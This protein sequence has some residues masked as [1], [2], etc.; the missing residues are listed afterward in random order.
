VTVTSREISLLLFLISFMKT[1][2]AMILLAV[3]GCASDCGL[4]PWNNP[5]TADIFPHKMRY[6]GQQDSSPG[7]VPVYVGSQHSVASAPRPRPAPSAGQ[8][9]CLIVATE[10]QARLKNTACWARIAGFTVS[11]SSNR[12]GGHAVVFYQ[13]TLNS[14]VW[15]YDKSGSHEIPTQSH[16]LT[17]IVEALNQKF[18]SYDIQVSGAKWVEGNE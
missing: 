13:P 15:M 12:I 5:M 16:D 3:T 18:S 4:W 14:N 7:Y 10:A 11:K 17:I 2:L 6:I 8:Q 9:D 1:I